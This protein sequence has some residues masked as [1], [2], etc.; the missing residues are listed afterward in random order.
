MHTRA[1]LLLL[2]VLSHGCVHYAGIAIAPNGVVW[3]IRNNSGG[4]LTGPTAEHV[5]ACVPQGLRLNCVRMPAAGM[6]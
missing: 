1:L 2:V 4:L 5:F 6:E 3:I